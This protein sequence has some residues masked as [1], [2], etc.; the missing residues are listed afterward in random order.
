[1][2]FPIV[3]DRKNLT[4]LKGANVEV[5]YAILLKLLRARKGFQ[6]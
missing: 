6:R 1:M 5:H 3:F 4:V 2:I